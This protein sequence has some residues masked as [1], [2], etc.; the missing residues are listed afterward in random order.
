[1]LYMSQ[2]ITLIKE[3]FDLMKREINTLRNT[4]LYTRLLEYMNN[5]LAGRKFTR[6][7]LGF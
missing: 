5:V 3:D 1:M 7:D 4:K 6:K 2:T